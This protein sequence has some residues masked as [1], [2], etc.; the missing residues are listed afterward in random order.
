MSSSEADQSSR[1]TVGGVGSEDPLV[2]GS[3][4]GVAARPV[5]NGSGSNGQIPGGGHSP[6]AIVPG[7][8]PQVVDGTSGMDTDPSETKEW[9]DPL[10]YVM[11]SRGGD[12]A[13]YLLQTI[14][15]EA[16]RL[17]VPIP[18]SATTPY[19]NTIPLEKQPAFPG[20]RELERRINEHNAQFAPEAREAAE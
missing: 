5:A 17:G 3:A 20:N 8:Q 13:A 14:D 6:M 1:S 4:S 19:I 16:Y 10:R 9:L 11:E 18:F 12:R 2:R 7:G 15:Q